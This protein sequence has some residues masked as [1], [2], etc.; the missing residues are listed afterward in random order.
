MSAEMEEEDEE[1]EEGMS[2]EQKGKPSFAQTERNG[3]LIG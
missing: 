3:Q 2:A 1:E